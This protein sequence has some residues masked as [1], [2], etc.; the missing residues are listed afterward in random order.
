MSASAF[1]FYIIVNAYVASGIHQLLLLL[2]PRVILSL[3]KIQA[4]RPKQIA[5]FDIHIIRT[6]PWIKPLDILLHI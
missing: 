4:N 2:G 1:W 5:K 3:Y 6:T